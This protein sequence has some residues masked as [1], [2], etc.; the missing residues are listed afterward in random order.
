MTPEELDAIEVRANAATPGPWEHGDDGPGGTYMGCGE[1][2]TTGESV[3]GGS[4][5]APSGD[6]YPR[7]GYSPRDDMAFIAAARSDVPALIAALREAWAERDDLFTRAS[8][9]SG[10]ARYLQAALDQVRA[11]CVTAEYEA[12]PWETPAVHTSALRAAIEGE[13]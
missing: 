12:N 1:V 8:I 13:S 11:L 3:M 2:W 10:D 6:L 9:A 5:A 7:G 4:I